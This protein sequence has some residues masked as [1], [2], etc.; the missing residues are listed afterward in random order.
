MCPKPRPQH[1]AS[2]AV[3]TLMPPC[4]EF[5]WVLWIWT[6]SS[7]LHSWCFTCWATPVPFPS[8]S[9]SCCLI[10]TTQAVWWSV[11]AGV[12]R[13]NAS[14][15]N[16]AWEQLCAQGSTWW[17]ME[18]IGASENK[19]LHSLFTHRRKSEMGLYSMCL[20]AQLLGRAKQRITW[21]GFKTSLGIIVRLQPK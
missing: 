15:I 6:Q 4:P 3:D 2:S 18:E 7:C 12:P 16:V 5:T 19:S 1:I 11:Q 21:D 13:T 8:A 10:G 20:Y 9:E 14:E 17:E